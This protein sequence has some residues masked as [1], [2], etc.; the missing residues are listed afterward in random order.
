MPVVS[1]FNSVLSAASKESMMSNDTQR[2]RILSKLC[3][4]ITSPHISF[5]LCSS[6]PG[7]CKG[8]HVAQLGC[9]YSKNGLLVPA[10]QPL[11]TFPTIS[12]VAGIWRRYPTSREKQA[13]CPDFL[14]EAP[15]NG[16]VCG[17]H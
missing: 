8:A 13:R 12:R 7:G 16:H 3:K 5:A 14:Y 1:A 15:S 17:F 9:G 2:I 11:V 4:G 6:M 10:L